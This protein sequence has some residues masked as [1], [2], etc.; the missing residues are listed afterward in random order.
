[1]GL[2]GALALLANL[3]VLRSLD[4]GMPVVVAARQ[5]PAGHVLTAGDLTTRSVDGDSDLLAALVPGER[6]E[7]L[8][9]QVLTH[10]VAAGDPL[11]VSDVL[12]AAASGLRAMSI[13]VEPAHAAGG[14]LSVGDRV[15]VIAVAD[16]VARYVLDHAEVL[17]V[18]PTQ[19]AGLGGSAGFYVVVAVDRDEAL[20][21]AVAM[22]EQA[23]EVVKST[24]A[25]LLE[26]G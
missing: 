2:A 4:Q 8:V 21:L 26:G 15:D 5:L 23:V 16:G 10:Q 9:G 11:R 22:R 17:Q 12:P 1:M 24:G 19:S 18:A 25:D 6:L 20:Q 7:E 3:A 13:P 14:A